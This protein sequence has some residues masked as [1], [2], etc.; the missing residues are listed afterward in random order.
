M[1]ARMAR[2]KRQAEAEE[3]RREKAKKRRM[4]AQRVSTCLGDE[5]VSMRLVLA[6][7]E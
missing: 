3:K 7:G 1:R 4:Y 2:A 5:H 6:A